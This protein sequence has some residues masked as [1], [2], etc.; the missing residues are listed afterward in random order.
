MAD[1][2]KLPTPLRYLLQLLAYAAFAA[3]IGFFSAKPAYRQLADNEAVVKL[4]FSH[5]AQLRQPC[6]ERSAEELAKLAPNMRSKQDCPRERSRV[7]V[8]LDMD[9]KSLYRIDTP[10]SGLHDD[11]AATVYRRLAIPAGPHRFRARL[12]DGPDGKFNYHHEADVD[13]AP[14]QVLIVDFLSGSGGF[15]FT[16]GR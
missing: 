7:A 1:S 2:A 14:G 3:V 8:E 13:L 6:R 11:G 9:G 10:P 5:S 16:H 4:S 15:V 12:A